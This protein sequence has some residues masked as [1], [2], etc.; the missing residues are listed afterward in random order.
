MLIQ[1]E[2]ATAAVELVVPDSQTN[3]ISAGYS[4]ITIR[5]L[6]FID[7]DPRWPHEKRLILLGSPY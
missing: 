4:T 1:V 2:S 6:K 3:G 7:D 5:F